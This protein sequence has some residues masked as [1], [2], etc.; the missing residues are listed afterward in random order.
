MSG[1]SMATPHVTGAA[2]IV[3]GLHP[4][5][6]ADQIKAAL[7]ASTAPGDELGAYVQG[8]GRVDVARAVTQQVTADPAAL[9]MGEIE[10]PATPGKRTLTYRNAGDAAV[11][12]DLRVTARDGKGETVS[13][14][15]LSAATVEVPA[16]GT[17]Q[18]EVTAESAP[19]GMY[20]G[21]VIA[22][23][24]DVSVRTGIGMRVE[25]EKHAVKLRFTGTDGKPAPV[26][27]A[28]V[29]DRDAYE[30]TNY[31]VSGGAMDL[32][33]LKG[34]HYTVVTLML[35]HDGT[36]VMAAD[37][38]FTLTAD[39]VITADARA[40]KPVD[41]RTAE[42]TARLAFGMVGMLQLI[43]GRQPLGVDVD[44]APGIARVDDV[45]AIPSGRMASKQ[46]AY[47][48]WT[49]W[50]KP[51]GDGSYEA[52]PYFYHLMKA[53]PGI[54]ADP[55]YRPRNRDLAE[56]DATYATQQ[57]GKHGERFA[58][59]VL[60]GKHLA[61]MP[62]GSVATFPLPFHRTEYYTPGDTGWYPSFIQYKTLDGWDN[63][64]QFFFGE[65][66]VHRAGRKTSDRWNS[67]VFAASL[68]PGNNSW[69]EE[70][71]LQFSTG[72]FEDAVPERY[73]YGDYQ[74]PRATLYRDGEELFTA[75]YYLP[76]TIEVPAEKKESDYRITMTADRV[77]AMT[78]FS[79]RV[80]AEW[81][82]RSKTPEAGKRQVLPLLAVKI[83]PELDDRNRASVGRMRIPLRL[84]RQDG[85]ADL[86]LSTLTVE[87]SYD[88]GRTWTHARVH[89]SGKN[90][91]SAETKHPA[92][93]RGRFASLRV[94]AADTGG[95][96]F[97]ETVIRAY[98]IK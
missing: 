65:T 31:D 64:D 10:P 95:N 71:T 80:S 42:P 88:D 25:P 90:A 69:R 47:Y 37:P 73:S 6:K 63:I 53:E 75:D 29:I 56:V 51:R 43:D 35:D 74:N 81:K 72:L 60:Y 41:V 50:A 96:A 38:E 36:L 92:G 58:L 93:A 18:V 61:W 67:G 1:T 40:A 66:T 82:F 89:A 97:T 59:P 46:F 30:Q 87:I 76:G 45:K 26:A 68:I 55:G 39:R 86:K 62:Y 79:T 27:F 98:E 48:R 57:D 52:S 20:S 34:H 22:T 54:P 14:F 94:K 5:W 8:S 2:A 77:P 32:R 19:I 49:Q 33:L 85:V 15:K 91:W 7:M 78:R 28:G 11:R 4:D 12:L 17:A 16:H 24:G 83:D 23:G 84:Q 9:T 3:A 21:T 13:P 70:N 44:L